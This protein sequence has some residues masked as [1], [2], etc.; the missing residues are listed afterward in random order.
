MNYRD[1]EM[2]K[3]LETIITNA[4]VKIIYEHVH[5]DSIDGAIWARS[6]IDS[7]H[8]MMPAEGDA[9]PNEETAML[10]LG[11]EM[12][13]ILTG[14]NSPDEPITRRRNE[15]EC[16]L[17]GVYLTNLAILTYNESVEESMRRKMDQ[18]TPREVPKEELAAIMRNITTFP[19]QEA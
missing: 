6:D 8:I 7:N 3:V 18:L 13:H 9:F 4:G 2:Y 19:E 17:V 1:G 15:A 5:D 12:G 14:N 10:V 16:D 11:H